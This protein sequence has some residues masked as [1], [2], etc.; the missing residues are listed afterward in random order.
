MEKMRLPGREK[1]SYE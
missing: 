1:K